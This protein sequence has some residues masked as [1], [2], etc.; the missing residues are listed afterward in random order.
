MVFNEFN[1]KA[2]TC[3]ACTCGTSKPTNPLKDRPTRGKILKQALDVINGERQDS[4]GNPEDSFQLIAGYWNTYLIALQKNILAANGF[5]LDDYK[6][7]DM[8]SAKEVAE[9]MMLFKIARMSGQKPCVDNYTDLAG[10]AGIAGD[11]V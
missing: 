5:D 8:L 9:M 1:K 6:L 11:M 2:C 3:D 10:Y 7:V 4:Y